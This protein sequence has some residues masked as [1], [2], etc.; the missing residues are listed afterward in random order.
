[1]ARFIVGV[2]GRL[3]VPQETAVLAARSLLDASLMGVDTH[4]VEAL[5]MYVTHLRAGGLDP[6]PDPVPVTEAGGLGLWDMQHGFGLAGARRIMSH[7]IRKA[8]EHGIYLATCRRTN[9]IGACGVYGKM[10]A[11]EGLIGIACQQGGAAFPPWGGK[12]KRVGTSPFA[13]VAPVADSFPFYYDASF[14]MITAARIKAC[15]RS[16][17]PLPEGVALD[18]DG[19]PTTDP[20]KAW[21]GQGVPIGRYKGIGLSM[22]C[23]VL[24]CVLSGNVFPCDVPSIVNNPE[25]SA[26]SSV[27]MAAIDP[28]AVWGSGRFPARMREYIAYV[29]SSAARNTS[30]PPRYPGRREGENWHDRRQ[31]GIPVAADALDRFDEI[32]DSLGLKRISA[33]D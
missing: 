19:L 9:H 17:T 6:K 22:C 2:F 23:E 33:S 12:D 7:A 30:D 11:D 8:R 1:M 3:G 28:E 16:G 4:G 21:G 27:F 15:I 20:R 31:N 24:T 26:G 32:A 18:K 13:F 25:R 5:D 29:E 14:A 10:A